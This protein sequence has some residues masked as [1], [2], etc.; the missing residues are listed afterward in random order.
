MPYEIVPGVTAASA[1]SSHAGLPLTDRDEASCVTFVTGQECSDKAEAESRSITRHWR[2]CRARLCFTW[3]S[4]RRRSGAASLVEHGKS[5]ATPVAIVRRCSLAGSG[6]DSHDA[7]RVAGIAANRRKLRPPAVV[8]VG[9]VAT[10]RTAANWFTSR[11]LFG[12]TVLVTR[13]DIKRM[14]WRIVACGRLVRKCCASRRSRSCRRRI[15]RRWMPP[16]RDLDEFDWLVFSSSNGV[17]F[18]MQ[19][20]LALGHDA[21]HLGGVRLAAIGPATVEALAEFHLVGRRAAGHV[22]SRSIGRSTCAASAAES[23][24]LLA[25]R[26][27]WPRSFG[28]DAYQGRR[29]RRAGCG[30]REPRCRHS[31][32]PKLPRH[33]PPAKIDFT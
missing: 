2:S 3:G 22:S 24:F 18:F 21:R 33:S 13:P 1:A 8:I 10:K 31:R 12:Q 30:V 11:P 19:R 26:E 9:D 25:A 28:R 20:L 5:A 17:H 6:N 7:G 29:D 14:I 4:R 23:E 32:K 27:S 15:G 16:S